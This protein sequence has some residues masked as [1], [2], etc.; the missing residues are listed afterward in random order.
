VLKMANRISWSDFP[1]LSDYDVFDFTD[2]GGTPGTLTITL[3]TATAIT[4][5][6]AL[7]LYDKSS[8]KILREVSLQDSNHGPVTLTVSSS[9]LMTANLVLA[10]AKIF[11]IH[12]GMYEIQELDEKTGRS[13]TLNWKADGPATIIGAIGSFFS[14]VAT[15]ASNAISTAASAVKTFLDGTLGFISDVGAWIIGAI[16][17]IPII[18]RIINLVWNAVIFVAQFIANALL[19][20]AF[21][22][23][24]LVGLKQPAKILRLTVV[25]QLDEENIP[26]ATVAQVAIQ[27]AFAI[28]I[29]RERANIILLPGGWMKFVNLSAE[30]PPP[31]AFI[32]TSTDTGNGR[33]LDVQC[34]VNGFLDN[35]GLTGAHYQWLTNNLFFRGTS[36]LVGLGGTYVVFAIR[37][38]NDGKVGC[39][40]GPFSDFAL[41]NFV[42]QYSVLAHEMGHACGLLHAMGNSPEAMANLMFPS[43]PS[44]IPPGDFRMWLTNEQVFLMRC[45]SRTA[46]L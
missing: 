33:Y 45:S 38:F 21:G 17:S 30:S 20:F 24:G 13:I 18:G 27:I 10:K 1:S 32:T 36:R 6:K 9:E 19:E 43:S 5:W 4:W 35:L 25:I 3:T 23:L 26:V 22:V 46:F 37:R 42:S 34:D 40:F 41:V 16:M 39:S 14:D 28:K 44:P 11:G 2:L 31:S 29:F 12:T 7:Q 8:G 15:G